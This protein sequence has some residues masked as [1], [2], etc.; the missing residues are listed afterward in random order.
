MGLITKACVNSKLD[1]L[2]VRNDNEL[3]LEPTADRPLWEQTAAHFKRLIESAILCDGDVLPTHI[4]LARKVGVGSSTLQR[5][6]TELAAE[7]WIRRIP[8]AG[9][10]VSSRFKRQSKEKKWIAIM[11]RALFDPSVSHWDFLVL[12][13]IAE[14]FGQSEYDYRIYSNRFANAGK[15]GP[16]RVDPFLLHDIEEGL[17]AGLLVCGHIPAGNASLEHVL[18]RDRIPRLEF[19]ALTPSDLCDIV[20]LDA[21]AFMNAAFDELLSEGVKSTGLL[22]VP[23]MKGRDGGEQIQAY[24]ML[25]EKHGINRKDDWEV[26]ISQPSESAG[27]EAVAKI[28]NSGTLPDALVITDD[29]VAKGA[30]NTLALR[31]I[32]VPGTLKVIVK[33]NVGSGIVYALPSTSICFD[34]HQLVGQGFNLLRERIEGYVGP[35]RRLYISPNQRHSKRS[36]AISQVERSV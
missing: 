18:K 34:I 14:Q 7:G 17:V 5:A 3:R 27:A 30:L 35:G 26:T 15:K 8:R 4:E 6:L 22:R 16:Q 23:G 29:I 10:V 9:T 25:C 36:Y 32:D 19:S 11:T 13:A 24:E 21:A 28:L 20:S 33:G 2:A 31:S 12:N 1:Y